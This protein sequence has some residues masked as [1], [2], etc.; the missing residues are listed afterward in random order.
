MRVAAWYKPTWGGRCAGGRSR[1][2]IWL[3]ASTPLGGQLR[4]MRTGTP[5]PWAWSPGLPAW[6]LVARD[7]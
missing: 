3:A 4:P 7:P 5:L 2:R 6:G 1:L